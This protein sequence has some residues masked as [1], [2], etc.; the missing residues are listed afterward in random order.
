MHEKP[1][2]QPSSPHCTG[3]GGLGGQCSPGPL[4][5]PAATKGKFGPPGAP[6]PAERVPVRNSELG[7]TVT[8][9]R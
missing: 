6:P 9:S 4:V 5:G 2:C 3:A 1:H 7:T 8:S